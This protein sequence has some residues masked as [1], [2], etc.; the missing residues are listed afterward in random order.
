[1]KSFKINNTLTIFILRKRPKTDFSQL[2]VVPSDK[3][4]SSMDFW[5]RGTLCKMSASRAGYLTP[6]NNKD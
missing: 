1:M 2:K 5:D 6:G 3:E 4:P